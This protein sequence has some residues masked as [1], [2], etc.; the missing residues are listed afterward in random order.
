MEKPYWLK[1]ALAIYG[2]CL[3]IGD[4][5]SDLFVGISLNDKCHHFYAS[6]VFTFIFMPGFISGFRTFIEKNVVGKCGDSGPLKIFFLVV[7]GAPLY[8]GL[9]GIVFFPYG[10]FKLIKSA[11][12]IDSSELEKEAKM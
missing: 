2:L 7:F 12:N 11:I 9:F 8:A 6:C 5:G 3:F 4:S 1:L 10:I